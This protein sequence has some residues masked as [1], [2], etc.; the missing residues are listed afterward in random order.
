MSQSLDK[1]YKNID[2]TSSSKQSKFV[3]SCQ[4]DAVTHAIK[5]H[6]ILI[7]IKS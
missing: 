2:L 4:A 3:I 7:K 6:N 5:R 1:I